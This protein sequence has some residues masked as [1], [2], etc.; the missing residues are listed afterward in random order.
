MQL[1]HRPV[2]GLEDPEAAEPPVT[3]GKGATLAR[4]LDAGFRVPNGFCV[5]TDAYRLLVENGALEADV[6]ALGSL[7]P[8]DTDAVAAASKRL[9]ERIRGRKVPK[10]LKKALREALE[11]STADR[12]AVRS[13]ATAEDLPTASFAGQHDTYL[14]VA[15]EDVLDR[16]RDCMASLFTTRAVTYRLR[17]GIPHETVALAVVVQEMVDADVAGVLF[18]ADPISGNRRVANVDASFGLGEAVVA[19]EVTADNARI[20][21]VTGAVLSYEVGDRTA[22]APLGR[23]LSKRQLQTLAELGDSLEKQLGSPQDVE[24]ALVDGSFVVLQSRPITSLFPVPEPQPRDGHLHVY[25]SVSHAQAM[26]EALPPLVVDCWLSFLDDYLEFLGFGSAENRWATTAGGRVYVDLTPYFRVGPLGKRLPQQLDLSNEPAADGLRA[27]LENRPEAFP[28]P[29]YGRLVRSTVRFFGRRGPAVARR[30]PRLVEQITHPFVFGPTDPLEVRHSLELWGRDAASEY[31]TG[32]PADRARAAF[33]RREFTD[34]VV[35]LIPQFFSRFFAAMLARHLLG[36]IFDDEAAA[37]DL[38]AIGKG[39]EAELVTYLTQQLGDLADLA[40]EEPA[41]A[42]ALEM[43]ASRAELEKV[44]ASTAFLDAFDAFL[45][46]FGHRATG[47]ID[48]SRPRWREDPAGLFQTIR[49]GLQREPGAHREHLQALEREAAAAADRLAKSAG[50]GLFGSVRRRVVRRLIA[51]YRGGIQLR[52]YPKHGLAHLFAAWHDAFEAAG[53]DLAGRGVLDDPTDVWFLTREE[54]F[55]ALDGDPLGVDF[56]ARRR[57]H[58]RY[59]AMS[60]PPLLTSEGEDPTALV[61]PETAPGTLAGTPV[62][63]GVVEG[64]ARVVRDP[65]GTTVNAGEVL[66]VPSCD[67]GWTPLFL[68]AAALVT[69]VGGRMTHGAVVAR[70]YGLPAVV[71]VRDATKEIRTGEWIR[72][73]GTRGTV[74]LLDRM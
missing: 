18:T 71:S 33:E 39:F 65:A 37:A 59:A 40:R 45:D 4:L 48:F 67:P 50:R 64:V 41:V 70:E 73:D 74:E 32:T 2:V 26:P 43:G 31:E 44:P 1:T 16:V 56:E 72:V 66:V 54:L 68:T 17:N 28:N 62:S 20:S 9:R 35:R 38:D 13:S 6:A 22:S 69:E 12:F 23:A 19:G 61:V 52:E 36:R 30:L 34:L 63:S 51:V 3:G 29:N 58:A 11:A 7:E 8:G 47:E 21:R 49:A 14:G 42:E 10:P 60:A 55:A 53:R 25:Y 57:I 5:T 15:T 27:L 24:W 46:E